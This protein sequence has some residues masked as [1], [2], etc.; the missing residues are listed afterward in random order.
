MVQQG[1]QVGENLF[2]DAGKTRVLMRCRISR[3]PS[4]RLHQ[5]GVVDQPAAVRPEWLK[6]RR[7]GRIPGDAADVGFQRS[8]PEGT[9][10]MIRISYRGTIVVAASPGSTVL[11]LRQVV[12]QKLAIVHHGDDVDP[13][14]ADPVENG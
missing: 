1:A 7:P 11:C 14:R 6:A 2:R 3:W 8:W 12:R 13:I 4:A 5:I 10:R 9:P